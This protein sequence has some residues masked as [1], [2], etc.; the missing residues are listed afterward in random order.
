MKTNR[1]CPAFPG[2]HVE[3]W[4]VCLGK[5]TYIQKRNYISRASSRVETQYCWLMG[6]QQ[7]LMTSGGPKS[8]QQF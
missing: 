8:D 6:V 7:D 4:D 1:S 3:S 2:S 5:A